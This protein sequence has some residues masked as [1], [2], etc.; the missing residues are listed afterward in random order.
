MPADVQ[1]FQPRGPSAFGGPFLGLNTDIDKRALA[2]GYATDAPNCLVRDGVVTHRPGIAALAAAVDDSNIYLDDFHGLEL[3]YVDG[4]VDYIVASSTTSKVGL[5]AYDEHFQP[6]AL[7]LANLVAPFTK[8]RGAIG[9]FGQDVYLATDLGVY[10]YLDV[11]GNRNVEPAG[12]APPGD[13]TPTSAENGAGNLYGDLTFWASRYN[14]NTGVESN[15]VQCGAELTGVSAKQ[16][17]ID[18]DN[19]NQDR[20]HATHIR[21][22]MQRADGFGFPGLIAEVE[23]TAAFETNFQYNVGSA[24]AGNETNGGSSYAAADDDTNILYAPPSQNDP[25]P[26][27]TIAFAFWGNRMIY[28]TSAGRIYFSQS[29]EELQGHVE[30]VG[31]L[32]YRT[33]PLG[34]K[35]VALHVYDG[36]LYVFTDKRVHRISGEF[37]SRTNAQVVLGTLPDDVVSTDAIDKINGTA[38]CVSRQSIVE[39]DTERGGMVYYAGSE[40]LYEFDGIQSRPITERLIQRRYRTRIAAT[41]DKLV[42]SGHYKREGLILFCLHDVCVLAFDYATGQWAEWL[43]GHLR[44]FGPMCPRTI[45][46]DTGDDAIFLQNRGVGGYGFHIRVFD[47][48][49]LGYDDLVSS[50]QPFAASWTC[51]DLNMGYPHREKLYHFV[52]GFFDTNASYTNGKV[53]A[54]VLRNGSSSE[55]YPVHASEATKWDQDI[56]DG[57]DV[58]ERLGFWARS[59]Q[60]KFEF[61]QVSGEVSVLR[62][63]GL[64]YTI[65]GRR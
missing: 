41:D 44:R 39:A 34:E 52:Q 10:K 6:A 8:C 3:R 61:S 18:I 35:P 15:A 20:G 60:P 49:T 48:D 5:R 57:V 2:A 14:A 25:P 63:Y 38:G 45:N 64:E 17:L 29:V 24:A 27:D 53:A 31:A 7:G 50:F 59:C 36:N 56:A 11:L 65:T 19:L 55:A 26:T 58:I 9:R 40:H 54:Y 43:Y 30:H 21:I 13:T 12:L 33:I 47:S 37:N 62:G 1:P 42:S 46:G 16:V 51:P 22:Y 32:S 4:D 23:I 28:L